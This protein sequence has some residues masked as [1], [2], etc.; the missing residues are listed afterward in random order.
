MGLATLPAGFLLMGLVSVSV[1]G[2]A[3]EKE[4]RL[5]Q[6]MTQLSLQVPKLRT[7]IKYLCFIFQMKFVQDC[8]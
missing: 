6:E 7:V 2:G 3:E 4:E 5:I 8:P 1:Q